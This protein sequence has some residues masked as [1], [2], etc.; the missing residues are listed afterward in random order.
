MRFRFRE[1]VLDLHPRA[2]V[3]CIGSN[4]LSAHAD[5]ADIEQNIVAVITEAHAFDPKLPIVL[6]TIAPRDSK[7]AP[8]KPGALDDADKRIRALGSMPNVT[9]FDLHALLVGPDGMPKDGYFAEDR[10]HLAD[11]GYKVWGEALRPVL[12]K[13]LAGK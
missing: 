12:E 7:E 3:I 5:P 10:L 4:D 1:D 6:C 11:G 2:V 13:L 8:T 9:L